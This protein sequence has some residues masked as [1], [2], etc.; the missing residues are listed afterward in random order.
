[1]PT[2]PWI[3]RESPTEG[4][5]YL[6]LISHLPLRNFRALPK[7]FRFTFETRRQLQTAPGLI[8]Y[9][10]E[11]KPFARKF[12]TLSVWRD[13]QS[14]RAFV[15]NQPHSRIMQV[16]APHMDKTQFA[17]WTVE[18]RQIPLDWKTAKARLTKS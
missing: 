5:Q 18:W 7:F 1:M 6:A 16:L 9:S 14:L 2:V 13:E 8:G 17:Q 11:A 3:T 4:T 15:G 12:W 10:L